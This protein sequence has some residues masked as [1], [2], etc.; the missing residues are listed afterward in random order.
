MRRKDR[1]VTDFGRILDVIE[2]C[3]T[4]RLG[5]ADG[6]SLIHI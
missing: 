1:E 6:L 5:L 3:D 2:A 4:L